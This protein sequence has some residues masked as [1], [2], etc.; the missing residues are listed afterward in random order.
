MKKSHVRIVI[1]GAFAFAFCFILAAAQQKPALKIFISVDME[2]ISG[3]VHSDQTTSGT[4]EYAAGRKW[5]AQDVNA[6][7]EGAL[8]AGATEV[9]VNDS[10]GS[11]RN[12]DPDDLHPRAILISGSPKPLSMM[13]GID[14]SFAACFLIGYHAKAGTEDAILDHTISGSVVRAIRVNGAEL[15]ELGLN[16]AIAGY[17]NVPVILVSGDTAVCRQ[18]GEVL[19]KDVVTVAVKEAYGRLA[20]KL[21]PMGEARRMIKAGVK[22]ALGKLGRIKPFKI[23][24]PYNFE[25]GYHV[26]AQAD[27]AAMLTEVKR[28]DARTVAFTA[29]DFILGFR[30]LRALIALAPAR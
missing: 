1:L 13:Q 18:A 29:D 7:V 12:I 2:G 9:V 19:G 21:V 15:P 25:L 6:A 30:K 11:M 16:A 22:D 26:S 17:Y 23:A 27:M 24:P 8:E 3:I 20:A 5:M 28:V 4:A 14:A 10:H